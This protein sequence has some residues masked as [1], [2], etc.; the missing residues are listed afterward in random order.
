MKSS[1]KNVLETDIEELKN[2]LKK[3]SLDDLK[4]RELVEKLE[5]K[6]EVLEQT[7]R[8]INRLETYKPKET[9]FVF[10]EG[11]SAKLNRDGSRSIRINDA[12]FSIRL[13]SSKWLFSDKKNM[14]AINLAFPYLALKNQNI[15]DSL[16]SPN[17]ENNFVPN[18]SQRDMGH[19]ILSSLGFDDSRILSEENI[20]QLKK[21]LSKLNP[22]NGKTGQ[23]NLIELGIYD[24]ASQSIN[25]TRLVE[26]L[27]FIHENR[28][29]R[30]EIIFEQ[31][32]LKNQ[33][34]PLSAKLK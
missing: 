18:K 23:E 24:V 30:D 2:E 19:L 9:S 17:L 32:T 11:F 34:I 16:F 3:L 5:H 7:E 26:V 1:E 15:A 29:L 13:P 25:K 10:R 14:N 21:D 8:G 31:M 28:G 33:S 27:K 4:R 20:K 6:K 22:E 12:D